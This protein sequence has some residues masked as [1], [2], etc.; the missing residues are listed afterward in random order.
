[1][2][3]LRAKANRKAVSSRNPCR[4][5]HLTRLEALLPHRTNQARGS[6]HRPPPSTTL[7]N[8]GAKQQ[9][10]ALID[11]DASGQISKTGDRDGK[12]VLQQSVT[13]LAGIYKRLGDVDRH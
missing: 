2:R 3:R 8:T 9:T 12:Q 1:M 11:P 5:R 7:G 4:I 13:T 6:L 10:V